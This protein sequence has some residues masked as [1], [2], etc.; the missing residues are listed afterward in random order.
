MPD[1]SLHVGAGAQDNLQS[2]LGGFWIVTKSSL[3][4][5]SYSDSVKYKRKY[6][7]S[8]SF[9]FSNSL[10][11]QKKYSLKDIFSIYNSIR[12]LKKYTFLNIL[13]FYDKVIRKIGK[14]GVS[15]FSF[16]DKYV[17]KF[18][19]KRSS[20]LNFSNSILKSTVIKS[21]SVLTFYNTIILGISRKVSS[22]YLFTD[23]I[24]RRIYYPVKD[25]FILY[26]I[27]N[28]RKIYSLKDVLTFRDSAY[29][30]GSGGYISASAINYF[31]Y[32]R[33]LVLYKLISSFNILDSVI[34]NKIRKVTSL[35][36]FQDFVFKGGE[37]S[38]KPVSLLR[39]T[40]AIRKSATYKLRNLFSFY[41]RVYR[42]IGNKYAGNDFLIFSDSQKLFSLFY[43]SSVFFITDYVTYT[44]EQFGAGTTIMR[45]LSFFNIR[46]II[47]FLRNVSYND[48][49]NFFDYST[50]KIN[51]PNFG[52]SIF[53]FFDYLLKKYGYPIKS[54][55]VFTDVIKLIKSFRLSDNLFINSFGKSSYLEGHGR[56]TINFR[57]YVVS[58][59][60]TVVYSNKNFIL[61]SNRLGYMVKKVDNSKTGYILK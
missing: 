20:V 60:K 9:S 44:V 25:L 30:K 56:S 54:N 55:F 43:K 28:L 33:Y 24:R 19:Y 37:T 59:R 58:Q 11:V 38:N 57:D 47:S 26:D 13:N 31:D 6:I 17:I 39:F 14:F 3:S 48:V 7:V 27:L 46:E 18:S 16:Y 21:Y 2:G 8:N 4:V 50:Y 1:D 40:S 45:M 15:S 34:L 32:I 61:S 29:R 22:Y 10:R 5:L 35:L 23:F 36:T 51:I 53:N 41:E 12:L 42:I 52:Y 49:L